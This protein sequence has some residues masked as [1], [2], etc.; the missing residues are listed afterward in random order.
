MPSRLVPL[1]ISSITI[2]GA[3]NSLIAA[4]FADLKVATS[5][6]LFALN[7]EPLLRAINHVIFVSK[8]SDATAGEVSSL[9]RNT[10]WPASRCLATKSFLIYSQLVTSGSRKR[11]NS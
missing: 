11:Q 4:T 9:L 7:Y 3:G 2:C 8:L 1:S 5:G 6:H 10:T